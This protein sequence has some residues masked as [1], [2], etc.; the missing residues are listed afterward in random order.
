MIKFEKKNHELI[1]PLRSVAEAAA[2]FLVSKSTVGF[3]LLAAETF[4]EIIIMNQTHFSC[5]LW[6]NRNDF[7][8]IN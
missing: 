3:G 4:A 5:V 7:R 1:S 2:L 8:S 6:I